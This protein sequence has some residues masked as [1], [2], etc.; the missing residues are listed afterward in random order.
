MEDRKKERE[1]KTHLEGLCNKM[2]SC[3]YAINNEHSDETVKPDEKKMEERERDRRGCFLLKKARKGKNESFHLKW[4]AL[5]PPLVQKTN[6]V[7]TV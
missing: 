2:D 5:F 3:D 1:R 7:G 6:I 4:E